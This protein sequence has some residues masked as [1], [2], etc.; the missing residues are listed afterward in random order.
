M[1]TSV[2]IALIIIILI[3]VYYTEKNKNMK[4]NLGDE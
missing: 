1:K 4:I 3:I 2:F